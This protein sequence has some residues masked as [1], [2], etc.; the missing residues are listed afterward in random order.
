MTNPHPVALDLVHHVD[1]CPRCRQAEVLAV[2][3]ATV[4]LVGEARIQNYCAIG[5]RLI[6]AYRL[7]WRRKNP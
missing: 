2:Q 7:V 6:V 5:R 4:G 3:G 1:Q